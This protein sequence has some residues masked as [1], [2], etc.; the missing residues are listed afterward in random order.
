MRVKAVGLLLASVLMAVVGIMRS[1]PSGYAAQDRGQIAA[2]SSRL[3]WT[4]T[5][6]LG[7]DRTLRIAVAFCLGLLGAV[8]ASA[9]GTLIAFA[10]G[11]SAAFVNPV[12]AK[13]LLYIVD[14]FLTLPWLFLLMMVRAALP[15]NMTPLHSAAVTFLLLGLLGWPVFARL[16]HARASAIK[17]A[18]WMIHARACGVA[19]WRL[20]IRHLLPHLRPLLLSQFL[21]YIPACLAAETNLGTLGL[22]ISEPLPS[23]GSLTLALGNSATLASS[24]WVYLPLLVL[25]ITLVLLEMLV[26]EDNH[27]LHSQ[28]TLAGSCLR[29]AERDFL[30]GADDGSAGP[31][32]LVAEIRP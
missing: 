10:I 4:G 27:E 2:S 6:E 19:G 13:L 28:Q 22:G 31:N 7:R 20:A 21:I 26:F 8:L 5:D 1:Q 25:V 3:H 14:L 32:L 17:N 24:H 9:I 18:D 30:S 29:R 16:H 15:L 12:V 11:V 23:W